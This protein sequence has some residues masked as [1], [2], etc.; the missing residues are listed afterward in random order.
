M[1]P[2]TVPPGWDDYDS[3]FW[4]FFSVIVILAIGFAILRVFWK[5]IE[6]RRKHRWIREYRGLRRGK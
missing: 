5:K 6:R 3:A 4:A 2:P 1:L